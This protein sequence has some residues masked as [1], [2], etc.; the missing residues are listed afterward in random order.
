MNAT[1]PLF[2]TAIQPS[3]I[4]VFSS[5]GSDPLALFSVSTDKTLPTDSFVQLLHD[6]LSSPT[7]TA[8]K[9]LLRLPEFDRRDDTDSHTRG[10]ELDQTV[11]HIQSPTLP[12]TYI[13][14]PP[15][16][17]SAGPSAGST[18]LGIKHPWMHIQVRNLSKE[19][20]FEVGI[21][22]QAGRGG[23][24]RFSVFQ[25]IDFDPQLLLL[26]R[27]CNTIDATCGFPASKRTRCSRVYR[28][29]TNKRS[30]LARLARQ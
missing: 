24:I 30:P 6:Y 14:C 26:R 4:S 27:D 13:Q 16:S 9:T 19:W 25:V 11:L 8:Q 7:T 15:I 18:V 10:R 22:D 29:L 21:V 3:I 12:T 17:P 23:I 20:S 1:R 2:S 5:T 28:W